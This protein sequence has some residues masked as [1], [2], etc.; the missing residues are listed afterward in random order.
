VSRTDNPEV[1]ALS[2][3][4]A[5]VMG[6]ILA[7]PC[8]A[9][10]YLLAEGTRRDDMG[11]ANSGATGMGAIILVVTA[12]IAA[13]WGMFGSVWTWTVLFCALG[14]LFGTIGGYSVGEGKVERAYPESI[15][16]KKSSSAKTVAKLS[17][18][19]G[20]YND[21]YKHLVTLDGCGPATAQRIIEKVQ[22]GEALT[23]REQTFWNE[24]N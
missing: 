23:N 24:V 2:F 3:F 14:M 19:R 9:A 15:L 5:I 13:E 21:Y 8:F 6:A 17:K 1:A 12:S 10:G 18:R 7:A 4:G 22:G 11:Q 20:V 16:P